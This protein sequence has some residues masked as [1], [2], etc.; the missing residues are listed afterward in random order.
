MMFKTMTA[1][2][3]LVL[4]LTF[5]GYAMAADPTTGS[6]AG[7]HGVSAAGGSSASNSNYDNLTAQGNALD[8]NNT[9]TKSNYD[10]ENLQADGNALDSNNTTNKTNNSN[11]GNDYSK[12]SDSGND[13]S[14]N[15]DMG[16]NE[17][18]NS[19]MGNDY[20][21][22]VDSSLHESLAINGP[23]SLQELDGTVT[24]NG[25]GTGSNSSV[26]FSTG[27]VNS[28]I[29]GSS[30]AGIQT[31]S[32]NTGVQSLNQAATSVTATSSISFGAK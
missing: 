19:N 27:D 30:F 23:I 24:D 18:K 32:L 16:N 8:S 11:Q 26:S 2:S 10:N 6:S 9:V 29:N 28:S 13:N 3:A 22:H 14:K 21:N 20:S 5:G 17:S 15:S 1:A 12:V 7:G 31:T 4:G 25:F